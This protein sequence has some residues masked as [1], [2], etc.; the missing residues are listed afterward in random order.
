MT[1]KTFDAFSRMSIIQINRVTRFIFGNY[2][3]LRE[4]KPAI[5]KSIMYATKELP[6]LGGFVFTVE[7]K[8][9]LLAAA[10]VNKTGMNEYLA[11]N[12]LVY[13][14]VKEEHRRT[15]IANKLLQHIVMYC[16]GDISIY[17]QKDDVII[18]M[19]EKF[20]FESR[21]IEMRLERKTK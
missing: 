20:G 7:H 13:L 2:T 3:S 10:V 16:K 15:G 5:Q 17:V 14:A 11:E 21:N 6:G 12:I 9:E 18:K 8:N 19:F 4:T 1:I